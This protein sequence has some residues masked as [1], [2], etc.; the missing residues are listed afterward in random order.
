MSEVNASEAINPDGRG[1]VKV[2]RSVV[3]MG[4]A[5]LPCVSIVAG[6]VNLHMSPSTAAEVASNLARIALEI[7]NE[8]NAAEAAMI[9]TMLDALRGMRPH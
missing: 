8:E 4:E 5:P 1:S 6:P 7:V 2:E 3:M 9:K